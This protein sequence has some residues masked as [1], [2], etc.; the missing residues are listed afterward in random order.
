MKKY[1]ML[2]LAIGIVGCKSA[3]STISEGIADSDLAANK[4]IKGHYE[5]ITDFSTVYIKASARYRDDKQ[6]QSVTAEIRIKKDEKILVSVRFLG[7]TMAKAL[8][9]P[10]EVKYYEKIN[11]NYFEGDFTTLSKWLGTDLDFEKLQNMLIGR[12]IDNLKSEKYLA[13]IDGKFYKLENASAK[14]VQKSYYFEG[15]NFLI[16]KQEVIQPSKNRQLT[17]SYP[18]YSKYSE[19]LFPSELNIS[20]SQAKNKT[21]IN[22]NYTNVTFNEDISFPYSVPEGYDRIFID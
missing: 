6:S 16:K 13:T 21:N 10:T 4:I 9:T 17:V 3:K 1:L 22:I 12:A 8:I 19:I 15:D 5:N 11:Q 20:A 2:L 7:I 18:G 14:E